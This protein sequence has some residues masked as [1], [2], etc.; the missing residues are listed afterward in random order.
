MAK[1]EAP[2]FQQLTVSELEL[3]DKTLRREEGKQVD[4]LKAVNA[5][6]KK[7]GVPP[8]N[9]GTISRYVRGR[10]H[11]RSKVERRGAKRKLSKRDVRTLD[12]TRRRLIKE[13]DNEYRVTY[14]DIIS[15]ADLE[16]KACQRTVEDSLRAGSVRFT[17]PRNKIQLNDK[18]IKTRYATSGI[19]R[20]RTKK[21]WRK[22]TYVDNK[23]FPMP[24]TEA[25]RKKLKQTRV[26][27]HLRKPG[28]GVQRGFTKPRQQHSWI[29]FPSVQISA[30]V[31]KS[32]S[33]SAS[34]EHDRRSDQ[35]RCLGRVS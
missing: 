15:A 18:D 7:A 29:G 4:A 12:Q 14:D 3:I 27:G 23:A 20:R 26:T 10:S 8:A 24:L 1:T 11:S 16:D 5:K 13:A 22:R 25:Q 21:Y 6:R 17:K 19:W 2:C 30:A 9:K 31:A 33:T 32:V 35:G 34:L 28:E